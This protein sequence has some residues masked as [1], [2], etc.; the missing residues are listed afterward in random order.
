M[1][2]IYEEQVEMVRRRKVANGEWEEGE[3]KHQLQKYL[4]ELDRETMGT[5]KER[6]FMRDLDAVLRGM[7]VMDNPERLMEREYHFD[8]TLG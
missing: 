1:I 6:I 7:Q 5:N 2:A 4:V 3:S 8:E